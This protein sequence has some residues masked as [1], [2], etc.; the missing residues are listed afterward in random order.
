[1]IQLTCITDCLTVAFYRTSVAGRW[2][3]IAGSDELKL[4]LQASCGQRLP[5]KLIAQ[6][7]YQAHLLAS[8]DGALY[9][10]LLRFAANLCHW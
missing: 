5:A 8:F 3:M 9:P 1:M 6:V 7:G 4:L 2:G 10:V